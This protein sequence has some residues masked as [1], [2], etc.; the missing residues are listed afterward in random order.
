MQRHVPLLSH[1]ARLSAVEISSKVELARSASRRRRGTSGSSWSCRRK[2]FLLKTERRRARDVER[3]RG[4][5]A[6]IRARLADESFLSRA[7]ARG[8]RE[9]A[10]ATRGN[11]G[12]DPAPLRQSR[13]DAGR[14][15]GVTDPPRR[16]VFLAHRERHLSAVDAVHERRR[17]DDRGEDARRERGH[18]A[19][20]HRG[21]RADG[22][23]RPHG[24]D[25]GLRCPGALA[26]SVIVPWP[27][28]PERVR[29]AGASR[30][31][32]RAGSLQGVR[33]RREA[34]VAERPPREP[35]EARRHPRRGARERRRRGLGRRRRRP[36]RARHAEGPRRPRAERRDVARGRR[37]RRG[38]ARRASRRSRRSSTSSTSR[39]ERRER[40]RFRRRSRPSRLTRRATRLTVMD[41]GRSVSGVFRGVN[42]DGA[43]R[44][45]TGHGEETIVSGD[46]V[47]F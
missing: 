34:Q 23:A 31:R 4:E 22:R 14:V 1:L 30:D 11:R 24:P 9:D 10:A 21:G 27:E 42:A 8:R 5:A 3:L 13:R 17:Q 2:R 7:P 16:P 37:G 25:A 26:V 35:Q 18:P 6:K 28:G 45:S 32:A 19:H 47:L 29:A 44:L 20:D 40:T 36:Q 43:L 41:A 15:S 39:S 33:P 46:V 38:E 12:A